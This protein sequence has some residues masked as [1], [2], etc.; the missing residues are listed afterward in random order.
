[1]TGTP[2]RTA[3]AHD[4][5]ETRQSVM[6]EF[7]APRG[8]VGRKLQAK[9]RSEGHEV[10]MRHLEGGRGRVGVRS[11]KV[12]R[13]QG[14]ICNGYMER[15]S[16]VLPRE[17]CLSVCETKSKRGYGA[18]VKEGRAGRG[19]MY[20]T[21]EQ[22]TYDAGLGEQTREAERSTKGRQKSAESTSCRRTAAKEEHMETNRN[23]AF[24]A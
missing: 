14:C 3:T 9:L 7:I 15:K 6:V 12:I 13:T 10:H 18:A 24:D 8:C 21:T 4:G 2:S 20:S 23:G 16:R 22:T 5:G 17:I 1:M 11:P 19:R